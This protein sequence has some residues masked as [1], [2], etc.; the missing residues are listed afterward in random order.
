MKSY[1][2]NMTREQKIGFNPLVVGAIYEM[3]L[4]VED[5]AALGK[6][7]NPLVVG[8]IYE[9]LQASLKESQD[10]GRVSI[11]LWSGQYMKSH[12]VMTTG[13]AASLVKF[14]SPCG[15]GNI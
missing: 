14:Q 2:E 7:F 6:C 15:R 1:K 10:A 11:P 5:D 12:S 4:D 9:M 8:A 13:N 3:W